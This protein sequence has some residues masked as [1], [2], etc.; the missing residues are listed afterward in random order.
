MKKIGFATLLS[1]AGLLSLVPATHAQAIYA[2][3]ENFRAQVGAGV[4][5]LRND[6]T[7]D[8]GKGISAWGDVDFARFRG[9]RIGAEAEV[10]FG[11]IITPDDFGENTFL[12]G[13]RFSFQKRKLNIYGKILLGRGTIT[14]QILNQSSSYNVIPAYGGGLEYRASHKWN[15]RVVNFELQK[16]P[17]FEPNTLSPLAISVGVSYTVR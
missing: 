4:L 7:E 2:A 15:I 11:G 17:D 5:Y 10:N 13:P 9:M 16:W 3:K 1:L 14:N 6:Y 8:A 12:V